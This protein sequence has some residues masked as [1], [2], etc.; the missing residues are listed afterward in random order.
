MRRLVFGGLAAF[1]FYY[2]V[3]PVHA[4]TT[5]FNGDYAF[6]NWM[7]TENQGTLGGVITDDVS[8][9]IALVSA[10]DGSGLD[11]LTDCTIVA[12]FAATISFEWNYESVDS[13]NLTLY[14]PFGYLIGDTYI[15]LVDTEIGTPLIQ[16]GAVT[17]D[18]K[19]NQTFGF[20]AISIDSEGGSSTT[21]IT[22]FQA[23]PE[24]AV[25]TLLA[26]FGSLLIAVRRYFMA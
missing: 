3:Q 22:H 9:S 17:F 20:R 12:P 1:F 24:P 5:G 6:S 23:I 21:T 19:M 25:I 10:D 4:A 18:V 8:D 11:V 16:S 15:Q 13:S 2:I 14:D 26:G 7:Y